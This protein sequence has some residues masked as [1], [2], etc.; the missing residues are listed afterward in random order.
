VFGQ[1]HNVVEDHARYF[2]AAVERLADLVPL[3]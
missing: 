2:D 1:T 3:P